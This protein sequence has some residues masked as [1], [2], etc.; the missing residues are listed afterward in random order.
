MS[1][2]ITSLTGQQPVDRPV[3]RVRHEAFDALAVMALTAFASTL[4]AAALVILVRL[5]N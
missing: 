3:R 5:G 1:G 4:L 2:T